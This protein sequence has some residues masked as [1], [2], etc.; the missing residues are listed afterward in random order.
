MLDLHHVSGLKWPV[1]Q[2]D[3]E[4]MLSITLPALPPLA[5][6]PS[7]IKDSACML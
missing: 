5:R 2:K 7:H 1:V 6:H 3:T 4:P